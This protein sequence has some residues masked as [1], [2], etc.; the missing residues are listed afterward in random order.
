MARTKAAHSAGNIDSFASSQNRT[1]NGKL[2]W[3]KVLPCR[4]N[5]RRQTK[6]AFFPFLHEMEITIHLPAG[7][8]LM[9]VSPL[10]DWPR[11]IHRTASAPAADRHA[12][13]RIASG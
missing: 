5:R 7:T 10:T 12:S 6:P 2:C 11:A 9:F 3:R 13:G 1:E 4:S 8:G